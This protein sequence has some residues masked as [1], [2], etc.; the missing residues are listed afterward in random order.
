MIA[1]AIS[2]TRNVALGTRKLSAKGTTGL[3]T[4]A[5][6]GSFASGGDVTCGVRCA[7]LAEDEDE[8]RHERKVDEEHRLH[9]TDGQ[10]E[11]GLQS[12]LGLGLA[13]HTLDVG[14]AAQG[15]ATADERA[16][17]LDGLIAY[18]HLICLL[19]F[20]AGPGACGLP[21]LGAARTRSGR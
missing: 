19:G 17:G 16:S 13:S 20:R 18:C 6:T 21:L 3:A 15:D 9:Q 7:S 1:N 8:E 4:L 2:S 5:I 11:D 12:T 10:E 14:S